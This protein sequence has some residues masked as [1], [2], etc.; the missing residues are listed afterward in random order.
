[1]RFHIDPK[2]LFNSN[3]FNKRKPFIF[4]GIFLIVYICMVIYLIQQYRI[5]HKTIEIVAAK[6]TI[7]RN[8][9]FTENNIQPLQI[10][11]KDYALSFIQNP[12]T[13]KTLNTVILWKDK[14]KLYNY[15]AGFTKGNNDIIKLDQ[16]IDKEVDF[17]RSLLYDYYGK[18]RV[19]LDIT[20]TDF[21]VLKKIIEVGDKVN[22]WCA[23]ETTYNTN[24]TIK[25][26]N[27]DKTKKFETD[28]I[29][30]IPL[31]SNLVIADI[32]NSQSDSLLDYKH[33]LDSLSE[34]ERR[35]I[36]NSEEYEKYTKVSSVILAL[37]EQEAKDYYEYKNKR[38]CKFY[39]NLPDGE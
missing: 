5:T 31:F 20:N 7:Y 6:G 33:Y 38:N 1:M 35:K 27:K 10:T 17:S 4:T 26:E 25:G 9:P 36:E 29:K 15:Y 24:I 12:Q 21:N 3:T 32:I 22:I 18:I 16:I 39:I 13:G 28:N 19:P 2:N 30:V 34:I 23:Y 8:Q 14:E 37:T 11:E